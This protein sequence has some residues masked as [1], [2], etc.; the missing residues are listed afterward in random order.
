MLMKHFEHLLRETIAKLATVH[1]IQHSWHLVKQGHWITHL[2]IRD[3]AHRWLKTQH[4]CSLQIPSS[5]QRCR[6]HLSTH[7][8][9]IKISIECYV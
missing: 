3:T 7:K 6:V 8:A 9:Y 1:I 5:Q 4:A 2:W